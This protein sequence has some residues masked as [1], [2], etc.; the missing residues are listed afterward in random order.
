MSSFNAAER[1]AALGLSL[2]YVTRMMG[3]FLLLPVISVLG[4]DLS[5]AT[6][7]LIGLAIGIYGLFQA[8]LQIPFGFASDRFGRKPVIV[9]GILI[10]ITGSIIA[11]FAD[12]IWG[13]VVGRAM[14]GA[15][16]ISAVVMALAADLTRDSQRTKIMAVIGSSIGVSFIL[17]IVLGPLMMTRF[18]LQQI[19]FC[20]AA[21]GVLSLVT[22]L[23]LVP[24][25]GVSGKDRSVA[26]ITSDLPAMFR[27][28]ELL[29]LDFS[30]FFL[31]L[32]IT[33]TFV[34][35]PL[36]LIE[37]GMNVDVHWKLYLIG[38]LGSLLVLVPLVF[39]NERKLST[40]TTMLICVVGLAL[41]EVLLGFMN[42]EMFIVVTGLIAFFG[43]L[44]VLEAMLPSLV[45]RI[46]PASGRGTALGVY[47][48]SQFIGAFFGGVI[49]GVMIEHTGMAST[50]FMLAAV[51]LLWIPVVSGIRET[52]KLGNRR[53]TIKSEMLKSVSARKD[54]S[55]SLL[56]VQGVKEVTLFP[57]ESA[58]Y[59]KVD[60]NLLDISKL[61]ELIALY[62]V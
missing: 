22:I 57:S 24:V 42:S 19:F 2:V 60:R 37:V 38:A 55:E 8:L 25:P 34:S 20:V 16:A 52:E 5:G 30:I 58:A 54:M 39:L 13:I 10:F 6:P 29:K 44:S 36:R 53:F 21:L 43:F 45:S 49:G 31:H 26:V 35:I 47:S 18:N 7:I 3:L 33:A 50:H 23:F 62:G 59:L 17:S 56:K 32:I 28:R 48:T 4:S 9:A 46:A 1:R 11:A 15:G 12:T 40:S 27:N 41:A 14:Q 51:C 61:D